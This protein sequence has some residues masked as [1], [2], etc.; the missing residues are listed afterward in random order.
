LLASEAMESSLK[1]FGDQLEVII[2]IVLASACLAVVLSL[3]QLRRPHPPRFQMTALVLAVGSLGAIAVATLTP[4]GHTAQHGRVQPVPFVT[5][6]QYWVG[7]DPS[8]LVV[9]VAGNI[10][11][12]VPLGFFAFFVLRRCGRAAVLLATAFGAAASVAVE[13]GQLAIASRSTDVDDVLLNSFGSLAGALTGAGMLA[14]WLLVRRHVERQ[15][16]T[17][18]EAGTA[19]TT[20]IVLGTTA[21][22]LGTNSPGAGVGTTAGKDPAVQ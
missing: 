22:A 5:V 1:G 10:A 8:T 9:Y 6:R 13:T 17:A 7:A 16:L 19:A 15:V 12:F 18:V 14:W 4:R 20:A 21:T 11:F 2:G 3:R